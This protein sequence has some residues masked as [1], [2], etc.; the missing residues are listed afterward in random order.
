[1]PAGGGRL[2]RIYAARVRTLEL[3]FARY[4]S[5]GRV[6]GAA[7]LFRAAKIRRFFRREWERTRRSEVKTFRGFPRRAFRVKNAAGL[8]AL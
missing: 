2:Y 3:D 5:G 4:L 1:M 6:P 7:E 8:G